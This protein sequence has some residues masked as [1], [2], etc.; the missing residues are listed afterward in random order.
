MALHSIIVNS[1]ALYVIALYVIALY[2]IESVDAHTPIRRL[3]GAIRPVLA[4]SRASLLNRGCDR[5]E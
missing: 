2:V 5:F 3:G 1:I 4:L